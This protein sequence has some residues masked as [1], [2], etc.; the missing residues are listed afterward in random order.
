MS[1]N[2]KRRLAA[3]SAVV[4]ASTGGLLMVTRTE[5][6]SGPKAYTAIAGT[7]TLIVGSQTASITLAN[8]SRNKISFNAINVAVPAGLTA[9]SPSVGLAGLA[10]MNGSTIQLR[11]LNTPAGGSVTVTFT[12]NA[13]LSTACTPYTFVSDVRQSNDFNGQNNTFALEGAYAS[14]TGPCSS[15]NVTCVAGDTRPCTTGT[16]QSTGGNTASV[17]VNDGDGISATLTASLVAGAITCLEYASTSD[18]LNFDVAITAGTLTNV[19]KTVT[20]TQGAVV[21]KLAWQYQACF[22]APYAFPALLPTQLPQDFATGN[23]SGNTVF[24]GGTTAALTDD[25]YTGL[26]LPC[27]AGYGVPCLVGAVIDNKNTAA[28]TDDRVSITV[29]V[30]AADP[31]MR[32]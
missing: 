31:G 17:L 25:T 26:L 3:I 8:V 21:G 23:F 28:T 10:S 20:F 7:P 6:A 11:N 9:S 2:F 18:Q 1:G 15:A 14:M 27:S 12:V 22:Q 24:N 29:T 13:T 4:L 32:F 5:A 19:T 16:I 30:P